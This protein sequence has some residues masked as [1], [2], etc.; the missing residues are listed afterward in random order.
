MNSD[1]N[2][3]RVNGLDLAYLG[4]TQLKFLKVIAENPQLWGVNTKKQDLIP[5]LRDTQSIQLRVPIVPPGTTVDETHDIIPSRETALVSTHFSFVRKF[6][7]HVLASVNVY[8]E[9]DLGRCVITRLKAG[10]TIPLHR[11][12]GLYAKKYTRF[13][14]PLVSNSVCQFT[15]GG[16]V[17]HL[18]EGEV[19]A[20]N[21]CRPHSVDNT[22]GADRIHF[23]FDTYI[24]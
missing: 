7:E 15:C 16:E 20:F 18:P 8:P 13:H 3:L 22:L 10:G 14:F 4:Q 2:F 19:W 12:P 1:F 17:K 23:I 9:F 21:N 5:V 6:I 11:D 24:A